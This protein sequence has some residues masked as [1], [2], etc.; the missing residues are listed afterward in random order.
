MHYSNGKNLPLLKNVPIEKLVFGGQGMGH[1][2]GKVYFVWNALPG[3]T[4]TVQVTRQKKSFCEG[5]ATDIISPAPNRIT[6]QEEHALSCSPWQ[7]MTPIA[8][9]LWKI[10]LAKDAYY[11]FLSEIDLV[12]DPAQYY[13]YRN[14][15]EY[16]FTHTA[17]GELT[18]AFFKRWSHWRLP[19][20]TCQLASA[21]IN[22]KAEQV[23]AWLKTLPVTDHNLKSLIILSNERGE[24][25]A[26]L[27]V[28]DEGL[29]LANELGV[30]VYYSNPRSP[31]AVPTK[32]LHPGETIITTHVLGVPLQHDL[33]GFF[34][35]NVPIFEQALTT[36]SQYVNDGSEV[37]DCYGGVGAI[38][39]PLHRKIKTG[40]IIDSNQSAI[41][42]AQ[43]T[44]QQ[45][46]IKNFSAQCVPTENI[47]DIFNQNQT[48]I[49]DPPRAGL[50]DDVTARL[51]EVKPKRIIYLSCNLSTQARDVERL[52][53]GYKIIDAK[54]FNFFPRTPHIEGLIV[55][56]KIM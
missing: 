18:F 25:I 9:K 17:T 44:I 5:Y 33:L 48:V 53:T 34:Q 40:V 35:V 24:T 23:L 4:V 39:L 14:K 11:K 55:L 7:I 2:D 52:L 22:Q 19:I 41:I 47:L 50:H 56:D 46:D 27:F 36:I 21:A 38:A 13:G 45:L 32:L 12:E 54:L 37:I 51:L 8:E 43:N 6:L 10:Q 16:S 3:E 1:L 15:I 30:V 28:R 31:A 42:S 20:H 26:G 29:P 49:L